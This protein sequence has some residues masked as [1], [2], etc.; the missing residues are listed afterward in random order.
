[1]KTLL[2]A[3]AVGC[4]LVPG[5]SWAASCCGGASATDRFTVP[6]F[7]KLVV[8]MALDSEYDYAVRNADGKASPAGWSSFDNRLTVGGGYRLGKDWQGSLSLP[9]VSRY[10]QAGRYI[11][12]G[13][14]P[15]DIGVQIRYELL[16]EETCFAIPIQQLNWHDV[17]PSIHFVLRSSVPSGRSV[18]ESR[19]DLAA[20]A[21]GSGYWT[22]EGGIEVTKI[23]GRW[24]N[25][26]SLSGGWQKAK[27]A[28][29]HL[30]Q[31]WRWNVGTSVLYFFAYRR[32]LGLYVGSSGEHWRDDA[33][34]ARRWLGNMIFSY[35][36]NNLL[37][38]RASAGATGL[39]GS[40]NV[41][42]GPTLSVSLAKMW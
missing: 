26:F 9:I 39:P 17:K 6:K 15:G 32:S 42:T 3:V 7:N 2:L 5:S 28:A 35:I 23:W 36:F 12:F 30:P 11:G 24:G 8:G 38:L 1:M 40:H 10:I 29:G 37:W 20:D 4:V 33:P 25:S 21:T 31:A 22:V 34:A 41:A 27:P 16:D 19:T 14:F 13:L 18:A